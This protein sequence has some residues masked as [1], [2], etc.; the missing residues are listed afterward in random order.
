MCRASACFLI[1]VSVHVS[2]IE[3]FLHP[4]SLSGSAS[5]SVVVRTIDRFTIAHNHTPTRLHSHAGASFRDIQDG[6][7]EAQQLRSQT[8]RA[9]S[10]HAHCYS[11]ADLSL[12][13][14][15][16][17]AFCV[18]LYVCTLLVLPILALVLDA[19]A[20]LERY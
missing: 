5:V 15:C 8:Q 19:L 16:Q 3:S 18:D 7:Q 1:T 14:V 11:A 13:R 4:L 17:R 20:F 10:V 12:T 2:V 6:T 9:T